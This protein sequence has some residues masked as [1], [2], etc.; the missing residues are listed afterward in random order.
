MISDNL[1]ASINKVL[2]IDVDALEASITP[3]N[4]T[5]V[6]GLDEIGEAIN[7]GP[8]WELKNMDYQADSHLRVVFSKTE[9]NENPL[10]PPRTYTR[11]YTF[12][13]TDEDLIVDMCAADPDHHRLAAVIDKVY[14]QV[15]ES[16]IFD[17]VDVPEPEMSVA[18]KVANAAVN[19]LVRDANR[20]RD[21][22]LG[23][24]VVDLDPKLSDWTFECRGSLISLTHEPSGAF[25]VT[26]NGE[27]RNGYE[28]NVRQ[29]TLA[30]SPRVEEYKYVLQVVNH[31]L[32]AKVTSPLEILC[33]R[34]LA[35]MAAP[36]RPSVREIQDI[37]KG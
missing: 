26:N 31:A 15:A 5:A 19:S 37:L 21:H 36:S 3:R 20:Y 34:V 25:V 10:L 13:W 9:T 1:N 27:I 32:N 14:A 12:F 35:A 4:S 24:R 22:M 7:P 33:E 16:D 29:E 11:T 28:Y 18:E 17:D 8:G 2:E 23:L 6:G 30:G